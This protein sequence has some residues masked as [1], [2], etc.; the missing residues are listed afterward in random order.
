M[1][2]IFLDVRCLEYFGVSIVICNEDFIQASLFHNRV[3]IFCHVITK[4]IECFDKHS[5]DI[6]DLIPH[7]VV[8]LA[9]HKSNC[10]QNTYLL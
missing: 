6:A 8:N 3:G 2:G 10:C 1:F 5:A 7:Y 9:G 4:T